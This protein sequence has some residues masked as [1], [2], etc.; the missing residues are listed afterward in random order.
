MNTYYEKNYWGKK[1]DEWDEVKNRFQDQQVVELGD[2]I[3]KRDRPTPNQV[4]TF[5]NI[6]GDA[7]ARPIS[8]KN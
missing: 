1:R 3:A 4:G 8:E 7:Q 6:L 2:F 5:L